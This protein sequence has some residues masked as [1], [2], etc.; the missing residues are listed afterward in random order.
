MTSL[1]EILPPPTAICMNRSRFPIMVKIH[2]CTSGKPVGSHASLGFSR[3][4]TNAF[5]VVFA[6][7]L[8]SQVGG[9]QL[10]PQFSINIETVIDLG[11]FNLSGFINAI[12]L[13]Y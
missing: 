5:V 11:R 7:L 9:G 13:G 10:W 6:W 12:G 4:K 8:S 3:L 2:Q 1:S